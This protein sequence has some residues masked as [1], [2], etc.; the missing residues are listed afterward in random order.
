VQQRL[1]KGDGLLSHIK[2]P[3]SKEKP[4]DVSKSHPV[5][6]GNSPMKRLKRSHLR[7]RRYIQDFF[8]DAPRGRGKRIIWFLHPKR[9]FHFWFSKNGAVLGLK[10]TA[11]GVAG[12]VLL[13]GMVY[14]Y[15]SNDLRSKDLRNL[16]FTEATKFYD[17]SGKKL[18]YSIYGDENRT[19]IDFDKISKHAKHA[20][21]AIEDKNF[22][23]HHGLSIRGIVRA[24]L[25]NIIGK[26]SYT[27]GGSTITQQYVKNALLTKEKSLERKAKEAILSLEMERLY[28]KDEILGFYLNEIPYGGTAYGVEAAARSFFNKPAGE[29]TIDES[30]MLAAIPQAPTFYSPYGENTDK[31]MGRTRYIIDLMREQNYITQEEADKAKA[32][33]TLKKLNKNFRPFRNIKAPYHVVEVQRRLEETYGASVV[34]TSGWKIITTID[35]DLQKKAEKAV[36][37]NMA[38]IDRAGG[39]NAALVATDPKT[40]QVLAAVG[41]RDFLN[42]KFGQFNGAYTA[43]RQP[44]SSVKPYTYATLMKGN[45]GAGSIF[46]DVRT[47]FSDT[48]KPGNA[49]G[50]FRGALSVRQALAQS[51]NIPAVKALYIAGLENVMDTWKKAG[52]KSS[53]LDPAHHGLSF[54]L[55]SAEVKLAEHV[56]GYETFANGGIHRDQALWLKITDQRD[57]VVDEWKEGPGKRVF[58]QQVAYSIADILS[59][60][61]VSTPLWPG[62]LSGYNDVPGTPIAVKTGT[63]N[64][65]KDA[66]MMGFSSRLSVGVW[67][68]NTR[69]RLMTTLTP[70][71]VGPI[72]DQFMTD[73]HKGKPGESFDKIKPDGLK[74]MRIDRYT[75]RA[76]LA[77]SSTLTDI[78]PSWF[79]MPTAEGVERF[80]IDTVSGKLATECTPAS[81]RQEVSLGGIDAEIPP[82][83]P[84]YRR[85][86]PPVK[87]YAASIG[88]RAGFGVKPT[89]SD[90]THDCDDSGP[91]VESINVSGGVVTAAVTQ[92]TFSIERVE[93][94]IDD[95][96]KKSFNGGSSSYSY[97]SG[98]TGSHEVEVVVVDSG[99]Y[100]DSKSQTF[101]FG[102]PSGGGTPNITSPSTGQTFNSDGQVQISWNGG[103]APYRVSW[104]CSGG[105]GNTTTPNSSFNPNSSQ[106]ND[107][108]GACTV[109]VSSNSGS[110]SSDNVTFFVN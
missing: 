39:N 108:E 51:R 44:G 82:N 99:T 29:L 43:L 8:K 104:G 34:A 86:S 3:A 101:D 50:G 61:S 81:A 69:P 42:P 10:L 110:G 48:F 25:N 14:A 109:T 97:D 57:Q 77:G 66:W 87:A 26:R 90:D 11:V 41:G 67:T 59:D 79:K 52:L 95:Q 28:S 31:L 92:G 9:Q 91:K 4:I 83:D 94:K 93:I 24:G 13:F 35:M 71:L 38:V 6:A 103:T 54:G 22:Y 47:N 70:Y 102:S 85:W 33:N 16:S 2:R 1:K 64:D 36:K 63:T 89:E 15:Y 60:E 23:S 55:G 58:D 53:D 80:T 45:Y 56:N 19:V 20:T 72:F 46:Y 76:P 12:L 32:T 49:D 65:R 100:R 37:D 21:I 75:G 62:S 105:S 84:Q 27:S 68:G 18:L 88:Q 78:F 17:R 96:I 107:F 98:L 40:G 7:T 106:E 73:A 30:A 74:T 5:I